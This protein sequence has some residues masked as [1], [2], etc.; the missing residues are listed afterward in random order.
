MGNT[1]FDSLAAAVEDYGLVGFGPFLY[2]TRRK[3]DEIQD[4]SVKEMVIGG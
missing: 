4:R 1:L 2:F 3:S